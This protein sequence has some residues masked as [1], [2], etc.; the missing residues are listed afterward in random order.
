MRA[1]VTGASGLLGSN[2]AIALVAAGYDVCCTKRVGSKIDHL[3]DYPL[4]W[5]N[6][7]LAD[8]E[9]LTAAF[10]GADVVFHCAAA[11]NMERRVTA[12]LQQANVAGTANVLEA[13]RRAGVGRLVHASSVGACAV[14][15]GDS[16][17]TESDSWNFAAHGMDDGYVT[18]KRESQTMVEDAARADVDAV[19]VNPSLMLGPNDPKPSSGRLIVEVVNGTAIGYTGGWNNFVDVRDVCRGM[20]AAWHKGRRGESYILGGENLSY[21][22]AMVRIATIAGVRR[23][24]FLVPKPLARL[25]GWAGDLKQ[26]L[27]RRESTIN[28]V[29]INYAYC[30]GY[31]FSSEK[32]QRELGYRAGP[33][34]DAI[35][36]AISWF[37]RRGILKPQRRNA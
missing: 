32:A 15:E 35:R 1:V 36:D 33:I 6:A 26:W 10:R 16:P 9:A 37:R 28:S 34:D 12:A 19:I 2:L 5:S 27:T 22:D 21:R 25:A 18:T 14:A 7:E 29:V 24:S 23:P 11:V 17:V 31:R 4:E 8:V 20:I 3:A 30:T 13:V